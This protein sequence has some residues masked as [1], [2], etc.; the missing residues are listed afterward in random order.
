MKTA[1]LVQSEQSESI[2]LSATRNSPGRPLAA[3]RIEQIRR[4]LDAS[5]SVTVIELA[6]ELNVSQETIRRDLKRLEQSGYLAVVHG[7]ATR[8]RNSEPTLRE[9]ADEHAEAKRAIART[10]AGLVP[11]N[12]TVL[13]DSGSTTLALAVELAKR[14]RLTIATNSLGVATISARA[15][16]QVFVLP[17]NVDPND[18]STL[19]ADTIEALDAF[20]FDIA[21]LG[22]GGISSNVGVTDYTLN[23]A[24]FRSRMIASAA[25][26]YLLAD[27]QKFN[28]QTPYPVL[29]ADLLTAVISDE[30]PS[31][32]LARWF[33]NHKIRIIQAR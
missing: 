24:R 30:R 10:A 11:D 2:N 32:D 19:S 15:Q 16:H 7:G 20:H 26:A 3:D 18:E 29:G 5:G 28:R 33:R 22:A 6:N 1:T 9:R 17:G 14:S 21:F 23:G 25:T 27:A 31:G 12:A 13:I 8:R 4:Q